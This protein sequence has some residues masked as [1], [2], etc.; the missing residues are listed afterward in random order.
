MT[1][2][3]FRFSVE[4]EASSEV[5]MIVTQSLSYAMNGGIGARTR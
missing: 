1:F 5:E 4:R 3:I 2:D